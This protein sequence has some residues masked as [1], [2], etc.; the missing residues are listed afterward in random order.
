MNMPPPARVPRS[1][2]AQFGKQK[3]RLLRSGPWCC[4][5]RVTTVGVRRQQFV[6][7][8]PGQGPARNCD[9]AAGAKPGVATRP[10]AALITVTRVPTG[11]RA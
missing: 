8:L 7:L 4:W 3:A 1:L 6:N 10:G 9:Q 2:G 5:K 11:T